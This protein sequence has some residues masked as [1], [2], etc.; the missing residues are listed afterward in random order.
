[1]K[2]KQVALRVRKW[3]FVLDKALDGVL[4]MDFDAIVKVE[5]KVP[6]ERIRS[7]TVGI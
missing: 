4:M 3:P 6:V 5:L 1:M 2:V 7:L